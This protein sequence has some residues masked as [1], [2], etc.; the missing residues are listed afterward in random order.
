MKTFGH[1]RF[2]GRISPSCCLPLGFLLELHGCALELKLQLIVLTDMHA[3]LV[4]T[5][6]WTMLVT[7]TQFGKDTYV[8]FGVVYVNVQTGYPSEDLGRT[9]Y[10]TE[11]RGF[12]RTAAKILHQNTSCFQVDGARADQYR[13]VIPTKGCSVHRV[14]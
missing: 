3:G 9:S 4:W 2:N 1:L 5:V 8:V 10:K 12:L 7:I 6:L 13:L 14:E 11:A